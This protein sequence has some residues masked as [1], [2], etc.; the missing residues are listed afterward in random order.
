MNPFVTHG[1]C[2]TI[3]CL[4]FTR[5]FSLAVVWRRGPCLLLPVE[6]GLKILKTDCLFILSKSHKKCFWCKCTKMCFGA[7]APKVTFTLGWFSHAPKV[8][9]TLG[10][11]SQGQSAGRSY[12]F[13]LKTN[14]AAVWARNSINNISMFVCSVCLV[15]IFQFVV[16]DCL[17]I[18]H[19][20]LK[21]ASGCNYCQQFLE[22]ILVWFLTFL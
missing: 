11:F 20:G 6:A 3:C 22:F 17:N 5:S 14:R 10:W 18:E 19:F 9:F 4:Q 2:L 7:N 1:G 21:C 12:S 16:C 8:T 13:N 15:K